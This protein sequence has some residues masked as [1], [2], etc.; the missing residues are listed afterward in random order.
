MYKLEN[1]SVIGNSYQA[2]EIRQLTLRGQVY[3][4][5]KYKDGEI[6][7][8]SNITNVDGKHITTRNNNIYILG[9]VYQEYLEWM[10][11]NN[12]IYNEENP[13]KIIK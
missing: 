9:K 10:W 1:W 11:E 12:I 2:P 3:N 4:H 5:P 7:L 6:I 8:T 13:I